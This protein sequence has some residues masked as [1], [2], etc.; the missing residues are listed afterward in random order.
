M[1]NVGAPANFK[2]NSVQLQRLNDLTEDERA[3]ED[4]P[5]NI[6]FQRRDNP[7]LFVLGITRFETEAETALP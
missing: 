4:Q 6:T 3:N 2:V 1:F 7:F 5:S